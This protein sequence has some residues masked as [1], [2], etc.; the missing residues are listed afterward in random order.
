MIE[1]FHIRLLYHGCSQEES[2][3]HFNFRKVM[4]YPLN[5]GSRN[6]FSLQFFEKFRKSRFFARGGVFLQS[7]VFDRF[8]E[9]ALDFSYHSLRLFFLARS[10]EFF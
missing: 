10:D 3:L 8:V 2:D 4:S 9:R 5:D 7:F 6:K 1:L